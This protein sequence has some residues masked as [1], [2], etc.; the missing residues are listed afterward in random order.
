MLTICVALLAATALGA[1]DE[2]GPFDL[3]SLRERATVV[4]AEGYE[5]KTRA[6]VPLSGEWAVQPVF[7]SSSDEFAQVEVESFLWPQSV[8]PHRD[9]WLV[10]ELPG[11]WRKKLRSPGGESVRE[12]NGKPIQDYTAA[13][14]VREVRLTPTEAGQKVLL[15]LDAVWGG[16]SNL[17]EDEYAYLP[18]YVYVNGN[19]AG[20]IT[21]WQRRRF[22]VT[23][24]IRDDRMQ[25]AILNG[26]PGLAGQVESQSV[27]ENSMPAGFFNPAFVEVTK[28]TSLFVDEVLITP[29]VREKMLKAV[30]TVESD[31]DREVRFT[32]RLHDVPIFETR[33][34]WPPE[35]LPLIK[36][37][38]WQLDPASVADVR[39][40]TELISDQA[41][42]IRKGRWE[43]TVTFP[44][45]DLE[46]WSPAS[47]RLY[48]LSIETI[49]MEGRLLDASI[50]VTFG[51]REVW[52]DGPDIML[53]G[54]K[55]NIF[56]TSHM[57]YGSYMWTPNDL[58]GKHH[59]GLSMD[60]TQSTWWRGFEFADDAPVL[61]DRW[62][63]FFS[64][65]SHRKTEILYRYLNNHPSFLM[66]QYSGNAFV[67]G[68]H[69]HPMQIGG[70][71]KIPEQGSP[72]HEQYLEVKQN[73]EAVKQVDP[74]R[75]VFFYR[76]GWGGDIR[77]IMAYLDVNDPVMDMMDWP[78]AYYWNAK[79]RKIEPFMAAEISFTLAMPGMFYWSAPAEFMIGRL[80]HLEHAAR[81]FGDEAYGLIKPEEMV[82]Q[83]YA[84]PMFYLKRHAPFSKLMTRMYEYLYEHVFP[85]WRSCG[86]SF[87]LHMDGKPTEHYEDLSQGVLSERG[88]AFKRVLAPVMA[89]IA[90]P[91]DDFNAR[92]H[93][94][95]SGQTIE[96]QLIVFNDTFQAKPVKIDVDVKAILD[97]Q[98][99]FSKKATLDIEN[100]RRAMLPIEF[101]I[102]KVPDRKNGVIHARVTASGQEVEVKPFAFQTFGKT[103]SPT[104]GDSEIALIDPIGD[105]AKMLDKAKVSY[106]KISPDGNFS[107]AALLIIGR[108]AY[109]EDLA[110]KLSAR[111]VNKLLQKGGNVVVFEQQARQIAGLTNEHFNIRHLFIRDRSNP[112]FEGLSNEDFAYWRGESDILKPYQHF[113]GVGFPWETEG[114]WAKHGLPNQ[115]GQRRRFAP[116]WSNRNMV[117]TFCYQKP[118][119]G[120]FRVL[121]DCGFDNLFTP[122]VEFDS[123]NGKILFCQL[124]VT[125]R[126]GLDPVSTKL[127]NL[128]L[129]HYTMMMSRKPRKL[130]IFGDAITRSLAEKLG[131]PMAKRS[132]ALDASSYVALLQPGAVSPE[133]V[134]E[135]TAF[136]RDGGTCIV[137]GAFEENDLADLRT[138]GL[139]GFDYA[140]GTTDSIVLSNPPALLAGVGPSDFF[141]RRFMAGILAEDG[142]HGWTGAS[143]LV[144]AAAVGGG[145]VVYLAVRPEVF[146]VEW[147]PDRPEWQ[148]TEVY[149]PTTKLY[150]ILSTVLSNAGAGSNLFV[151]LKSLER[152]D[153]IYVLRAL[154]FDPMQSYTW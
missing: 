133:E 125:N 57:Y 75:P 72:R 94:Y 4:T 120:N 50:P 1:G 34:I 52:V 26:V 12:L 77:A 30:I 147:L 33:K 3:G 108:N 6:R 23:P 150:R 38:D 131:F 129:K 96:K 80:G 61:S 84:N 56:G 90:G 141:Y 35:Q 46:Y 11:N 86:L 64:C 79:Q 22:D 99:I 18:S 117:A 25:I 40:A 76:L 73:Y 68:P 146:Q 119:A 51:F 115:W 10:T 62:G 27:R 48:W 101:V 59:L 128:M 42:P 78:L 92:D 14:L 60:R 71:Q 139:I 102:P 151:D 55:I 93:A 65:D 116:Q 83:A 54:M 118:Q 100:G 134:A 49:D 44:C 91:G 69:S 67:N 88:K 13:W 85:A 63:H 20:S 41:I 111:E 45:S 143:G 138:A 39:P 70:M 9:Q 107:Q 142:T 32:A 82:P 43:V 37:E 53:N 130:A 8:L 127:V 136:V 122:L 103:Q 15:Y 5:L 144:N 74:A 21:A 110:G 135:V 152:S 24:Y 36:P 17:G 87:L 2:L 145:Q 148:E 7:P 137:L 66:W 124:D 106:R 31:A 149:W 81:L 154:D 16:I 97:G 89:Y 140:V 58:A 109:N 153:T 123:L 126:Y 29:S 105:T 132:E 95:S 98:E 121:L 104:I 19:Y 28:P 114:N 47:P 113:D 112:L